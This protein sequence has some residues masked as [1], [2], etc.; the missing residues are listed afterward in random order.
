[1][2]TLKK[3]ERE[4]KTYMEGKEEDRLIYKKDIEPYSK[5]PI[6]VSFTGLLAKCSQ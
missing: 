6:S 4:F 2:K 3:L 5:L 1:M